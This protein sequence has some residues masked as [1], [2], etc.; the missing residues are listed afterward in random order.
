MGAKFRVLVASQSFGKADPEPIRLLESAGCEL[1]RLQTKRPL[2]DEEIA[3][4]VA[5]KGIHGII[6]GLDEIGPLTLASKTLKAVSRHG[7]GVDNIDFEAAKRYNVTITNTPSTNASGVADLVM[8]LILALSRRLIEVHHCLQNDG[9][10]RPVGLE[11]GNKVL[12]IVGYGRVGKLV[13]RRALAFD[14][15]VVV[16]D[17]YIRES[18]DQITVC[19]SLDDLLTRSD[20]VTLHLPKTPETINLLD[21]AAIAK[22]K[23][24]SLLINTARGE[25]VDEQALADAVRSGRLGGAGVDVYINEPPVDSPL[26]GVPGIIT[27]PH[28]G[29]LTDRSLKETSLICAQN[30]LSVLNGEPCSHIVQR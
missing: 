1:I 12:G 27:T 9:W 29:A 25:L 18:D 8:C 5:K 15:D 23:R 11:L 21:A 2:K 16:Y 19:R 17:P 26:K 6:A 20:I 3:Q 24:G 22:M 14:A 30:L 4:L 28:I 10:E 13:A 7:T